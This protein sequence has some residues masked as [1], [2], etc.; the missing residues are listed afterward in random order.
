MCQTRGSGFEGRGHWRTNLNK[1]LWLGGS[2]DGGR[3][4][5]TR[6]PKSDVR[7]RSR[8][9]PA[10]VMPRLPAPWANKQIWQVLWLGL[11]GLAYVGVCV[12]RFESIIYGIGRSTIVVR[13]AMLRL[14]FRNSWTAL[15]VL[16]DENSILPQKCASVRTRDEVERHGESYD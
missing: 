1:R 3:R 14:R 12:M 4:A 10:D 11:R 5:A 2:A 13:W 7:R 6:V 9:H 8:S 16:V 15:R